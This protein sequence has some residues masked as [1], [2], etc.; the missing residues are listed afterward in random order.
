[1][2]DYKCLAKG[3]N[4]TFSSKSKL[5]LISLI[6]WLYPDDDIEVKDTNDATICLRKG[7]IDS[8]WLA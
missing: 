7:D 6:I 4:Y 8:I 2:I 5:W 3:K 1:M